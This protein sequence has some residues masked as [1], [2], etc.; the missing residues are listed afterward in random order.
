MNKLE[1]L[2]EIKGFLDGYNNDLK[3]LVNVETDPDSNMA[4]C[5]IHEP[6]KVPEQKKV[7]YTPFMYMKD[8]SLNNLILYPHHPE[9]IENK[10]I[11]YGITITPLKT[12]NHKRLKNGYCFKISSS[13]SYNAII[14]FLK[15]GKVYPYDCYFSADNGLTAKAIG[16]EKQGDKLYWNKSVSGYNLDAIDIIDFVYLISAV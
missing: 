9:L 13:K 10:K 11:Q 7:K 14:D 1:V 6:G 15:D 2:S 8:L 16:D 5:I 3:Y 4:D 12:G